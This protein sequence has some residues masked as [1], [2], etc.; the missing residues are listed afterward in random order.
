M[1]CPLKA[2]DDVRPVD[3]QLGNLHQGIEQFF[4]QA[5]GEVFV[6]R[7]AAHVHKRQHRDGKFIL[8]RG[9]RRGGFAGSFSDRLISAGNWLEVAATCSGISRSAIRPPMANT[10]STMNG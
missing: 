4:G 9:R 5:I 7:V 2:K 6:F 3:F 8:L 10:S 1:F